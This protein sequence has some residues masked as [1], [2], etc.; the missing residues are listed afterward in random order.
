VLSALWRQGIGAAL[1]RAAE[2]TAR[3]LGHDRISLTVG[4]DNPDARRLYERLGYVDWARGPVVGTW[5]EPGHD[6]MPVTL[7]LVCDVLV[8]NL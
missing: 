7:S 1:I 4:R 3:R 8:K 5:Q 6:G 2:G